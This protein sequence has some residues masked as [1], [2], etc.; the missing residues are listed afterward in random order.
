MDQGTILT[1]YLDN[2]PQFPQPTIVLIAVSWVPTI[3]GTSV[4]KTDNS[5]CF[6]ELLFWWEEANSKDF[7]ARWQGALAGLRP[8]FSK[9]WA[10]GRASYL[11]AW[12]L[13]MWSGMSCLMHK[14]TFSYLRLLWKETWLGLWIMKQSRNSLFLWLDII[15]STSSPSVLQW[16]W[17]HYQGN[18]N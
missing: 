12:T 9:K 6:L 7:S 1:R 13:E 17:W 5:S 14:F 8:F 18:I 2:V 11:F 16:L 3:P 4:N 15:F 10:Q